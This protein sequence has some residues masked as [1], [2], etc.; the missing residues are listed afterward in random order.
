M[1][2][3]SRRNLAVATCLLLIGGAS[4]NFIE[5]SFAKTV[6]KFFLVRRTTPVPPASASFQINDTTGAA[7]TY[8]GPIPELMA[9]G[10]NDDGTYR[11]DQFGFPFGLTASERTRLATD[12]YGRGYG[13]YCLRTGLG[14]WAASGF[15]VD[16]TTLQNGGSRDTASSATWNVDRYS[17]QT[18]YITTLAGVAGMGL[19]LEPWGRP[20]GYGDRS[21][22]G[23]PVHATFITSATV[24]ANAAAMWNNYK[25]IGDRFV[26]AGGR[27]IGYATQNEWSNNAVTIATAF[28]TQADYLTVYDYEAS[29]FAAAFPEAE[30]ITVSSWDGNTA[31][32]G[33]AIAANPTELGYMT[34]LTA[35]FW[36][37]HNISTIALAP[38]SIRTSSTYNATADNLPRSSNEFWLATGQYTTGDPDYL[39]PT[40]RVSLVGI[41]NAN[42]IAYRGAAVIPTTIHGIKQLGNVSAEGYAWVIG[43]YNGDATN[44]GQLPTYSQSWDFIPQ[45]EFTPNSSIFNA[46]AAFLDSIPRNSVIYGVTQDA[47]LVATRRMISW[48]TP[49]NKWGFMA[50]NNSATATRFNLTFESGTSRT[51]NTFRYD[52]NA[53]QVS[54]SVQSGSSFFVDVP[55]YSIITGTESSGYDPYPVVPTLTVTWGGG[56]ASGNIPEN[57]ASGTTI[58]TLSGCSAYTI[59]SN[60]SSVISIASTSLKTAIALDYESVSSYTPTIRCINTNNR[61]V[62]TSVPLTVTNTNDGPTDISLSGSTAT[63]TQAQGDTIGSLSTTDQDVGDTFTYSF[64]APNNSGGNKVQLNGAGVGNNTLQVGSAAPLT[65]STTFDITIRSTDSGGLSTD[66]TFTITVIAGTTDDSGPLLS[67]DTSQVGLE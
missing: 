27:V 24:A 38:D 42:W 34:A 44:Y 4:L 16:G 67:I 31:T 35:S 64:V 26:A 30:L 57:T 6:S 45:G 60:P 47:T 52:I 54:V 33:A 46:N 1:T 41:I 50:V 53:P 37:F 66:K 40:Q 13:A 39:T 28:H 14:L 58:A 5:S 29:R 36:S 8:K 17:G 19:C 15:S 65:A 51:F 9:D 10:Q 25:A 49:L 32:V 20:P 23:V 61:Y 59:I 21:G 62:V 55:A 48:K 63:N 7:Q 56:F 18:T 2:L 12:V 3:L 43:R 11:D 22:L